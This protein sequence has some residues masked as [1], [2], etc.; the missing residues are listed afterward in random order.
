MPTLA[1]LHVIETLA[2]HEGGPP[3][4]VAGLATAQRALG[5]DAQ[6]LCGGGAGGAAARGDAGPIFTSEHVHCCAGSDTLSRARALR[7]WL[8][9]SLSRFDVVHIHHLWRLVPT[10]TAWNC[11]AQG[12]PY[13]IAPHA[14]LS[15]WALRQKQ[16]KKSLARALAW[17]GLLRGAAG[18]QALND[19]EAEEIH[20]L[21]GAVRTFVV[22]N[23]VSP[24]ELAP[25][26]APEPGWALSP[27]HGSRPFLLFLARL[28]PMKGP[29]LLLEAFAVIA[30]E[31][32][33]LQLVFAGADY[34]LLTALRRRT[35]ALEL[36]ARCHFLGLVAGPQRRW[37]LQQTLC[38]CQPSRDEG[39]SLS[40]LEGMACSRPVVISERC[41]FAEVQLCGAG[42]VV[43]LSISALAMALRHFV[44]HA[45]ER[46]AA[47]TRGRQLVESRYTWEA[48]ARQASDMYRSVRR[49]PS[50]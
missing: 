33:S 19:L 37:L 42:R 25:A 17:N 26:G 3:R 8:R 21:L 45:S 24:E 14:G 22:P 20:A 13:L 7:N 44:A 2:A 18:L 28:H 35:A 50:R 40:I 9:R 43:P 32:P 1:V 38:L 49:T 10:L 12:V 15:P 27:P 48:V 34:G 30:H 46:A 16:L 11:R 36:T 23:G 41:K 5:I 4:V 6:V 39:F 47:G 31:F 29:D